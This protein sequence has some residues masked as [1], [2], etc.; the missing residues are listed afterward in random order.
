[1]SCP[2]RWKIQIIHKNR[3]STSKIFRFLF[4]CQR[5]FPYL[6]VDEWLITK[7]CS[8]S[9]K[10]SDIKIEHVADRT[11]CIDN[12]QEMSCP[13]RFC[14]QRWKFK[15]FLK[16]GKSKFYFN[17]HVRCFPPTWMQRN[18]S[19]NKKFAV[20]LE[21]IKLL[22]QKRCGQDKVHL[23]QP[24]REQHLSIWPVTST[25]NFLHCITIMSTLQKFN[26]AN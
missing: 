8:N 20:I 18:I 10:K 1:M 4:P 9:G 7:I 23:W 6:N 19:N 13:Q 12:V 15:L 21:K 22:D 2:Q 16:T 25:N 26:I 3:N 14:P 17:L 5:S 11:N 24:I